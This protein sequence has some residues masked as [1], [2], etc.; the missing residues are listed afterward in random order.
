[1]GFFVVKEF[2]G[3][4]SAKRA[5]MQQLWRDVKNITKNGT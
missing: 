2:T 1:M 4:N 5:G 3:A